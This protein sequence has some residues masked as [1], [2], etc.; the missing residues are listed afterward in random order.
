MIELIMH[1][2]FKADEDKLLWDGETLRKQHYVLSGSYELA[3]T[4]RGL[5]IGDPSAIAAPIHTTLRQ[6]AEQYQQAVVEM[7]KKKAYCLHF[8]K[9]ASNRAGGLDDLMEILPANLCQEAGVTSWWN[10]EA[11]PLYPDE[12][13]AFLKKQDKSYQVLV[14]QAI[15]AGICQ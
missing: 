13:D 4:F 3:V 2:L 12:K 8:L 9:L 5:I 1:Y 14:L 6:A 7:K 11:V 15:K 10:E